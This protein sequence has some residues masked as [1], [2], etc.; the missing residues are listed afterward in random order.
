MLALGV[1]GGFRTDDQKYDVV[2]HHRLVVIK[3]S[4]AEGLS[5]KYPD[6]V[7]SDVCLKVIQGVLIVPIR[8]LLL[9]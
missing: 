9:I 2:K 1:D 5:V 4:G 6:E 8:Y 3:E 7:R